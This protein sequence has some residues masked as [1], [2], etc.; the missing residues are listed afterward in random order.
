MTALFM[1]G[2]DNYGSG[3]TGAANMLEGAWAQVPGS[4]GV[5]VWGVGTGLESYQGSVGPTRVVLSSTQSHVYQSFRYSV[6]GLPINNTSDIIC[7][8]R[9]VSN[10]VIAQLV[11]F[12][13]GAVALTKADFTLIGATQGPVLVSRTWHFLEM[14]FDQ[15]GGNFNLRVDDAN[16]SQSPVIAVT[17]QTWTNPVAQ[18]AFVDQGAGAVPSWIDDVFIRNASGS[19]N[20]GW[21]GD[22]RIA[23]LLVDGDTATTGWSANRYTELGAGILDNT[24]ANAFVSSPTATSLNIGASDFTLE[25]FFRLQSLPTSTNKS[26]LWSR[27]DQLANQRSYEFFL[28]S[29]SL[30]GGSLCFQTST[31]GTSGTITQSIIYPWTPAL[32]TWYHLAVVR[33]SNQLLLF[34]NGAQFGLPISD[35]TTYFAG[36]S[37]LGLGSEVNSS[38]AV[39]NTGFDG[40]I[41]EIRFT[42]GFARY[43]SNFTVP[44]SEFPRNVGGDPQ[45]ADVVLLAGFDTVIQDE[46]SFARSFAGS[47]G[48]V[49]FTPNDG[50]S[51]GVW[52]VIGKSI[53]DDNTYINAPFIPATSILTV[54]VKPTNTNTV[55]VGTK[56]GTVAAVYTFK[57]SLAS[58]F[59]VLIDTTIQ[60]TLQNLFNAINSG[61]GAGTKYGTSTTAN[62]DVFA[63]QL[64]AGQMQVTANVPGTAGN[65][66]ATSKS[67]FTGGWTGSTLAGGVNIP[68]PS[69][70]KLQRLPPATTI[71]SAV[72]VSLRSFKSDAGAGSI[73]SALVGAIG[74]VATGSTHSLS[75]NPTYYNDIYETD[76]DTSGPITPTTL[77]NGAIQ[78]NRDT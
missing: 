16:A 4:I 7:E 29:Q 13:T 9:D 32:N 18:I 66:I 61:P 35:S 78:V 52:P 44:T 33:A 22:R 73:N 76:P 11:A 8:F 41:D 26:T 48:S 60:A 68:G 30:N 34:V 37:P 47:N 54:T 25:G 31:D 74:G 23:T 38:G 50:A 14:E 53:P 2:F 63:T 20:N 45:F 57:T 75:V 28:G 72:Q 55:T 49:Q 21:L 56:D 64:P 65:A 17:G 6:D 46:S 69:N 67:G 19:Q 43:T 3:S 40:W 1:D 71:V 24:H 42:N 77:V 15:A 59:D 5:P 51:V 70:F 58:A 39:A 10:V 27:W 36:T 12:S 62:F